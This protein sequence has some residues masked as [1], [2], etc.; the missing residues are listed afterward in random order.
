MTEIKS[1]DCDVET[2]SSVDLARCGAYKYAEAPDF[3]ILPFAY[4]VNDGPVE[5]IDLAQGEKIPD[6]ILKA[7]TDE[8]V[9]KISYHAAF[10]R[11]CL[12]AHLRKYYPQYFR[13]YSIPEDS[14]GDYL[15]PASWRC[16]MVW[17]SYLGLPRSLK[18]VGAVLRLEEQKMSEGADLIRYFCQ[19]CV[20]TKKNGGRTRNLPEHDPEKWELFKAYNKRD[21]EVELAIKARLAKFPVP[22]FLWDEYR[23]DQEINDRGIL[24]DRTLVE[25][26]IVID[27]KTKDALRARMFESTGLDN[28]N[29][30]SQ[31]KNWLFHITDSEPQLHG[32]LAPA[33][34]RFSTTEFLDSHLN[35]WYHELAFTHVEGRATLESDPSN[36]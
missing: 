12:S 6:A 35:N 25:Q 7:L 13:S 28:P 15:D 16:S 18:G 33:S 36:T 21:V 4:S 32:D 24:V 26:A 20:P 22:D 3:E 11:V 19:P 5:V 31:M 1:I 23:L 9:V 14:V 10:E 29:S 2:F 17:A 30:V 8:N 34:R 27:E